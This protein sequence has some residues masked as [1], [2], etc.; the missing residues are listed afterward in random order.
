MN[1]WRRPLNEVRRIS[2][3]MT[4]RH[5]R[6]MCLRRALLARQHIPNGIHRHVPRRLDLLVRTLHI[7]PRLQAPAL[8]L[9]PK[10]RSVLAVIAS[11][12][13]SVAAAQ[14]FW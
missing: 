11:G 3:P 12:S 6:S 4:G 2:V 8:C 9:G 1:A 5:I 7:L 13:P 14:C 10:Q